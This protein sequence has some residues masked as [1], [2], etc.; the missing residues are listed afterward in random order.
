MRSRVRLAA[1]WERAG[2]LLQAFPGWGAP[3]FLAPSDTPCPD[4]PQSARRAHG[5][6]P[7]RCPARAVVDEAVVDIRVQVLVWVRRAHTETCLCTCRHALHEILSFPDCDNNTLH[8]FTLG[9]CE[10]EEKSLKLQAR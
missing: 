8:C 10:E 7:D 9:E 6:A 3:V 1:S 2:R 5:R 4:A